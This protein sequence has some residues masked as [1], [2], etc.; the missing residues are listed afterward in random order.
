MVK[1]ATRDE[2][3]ALV[4]IS[5]NIFHRHFKLR[6]KEYKRLERFWAHMRRLSR[7]KDEQ[8]VVETIQAGEGLTYNPVASRKRDRIKVVQRG[9]LLPAMILPVMFQVLSDLVDSDESDEE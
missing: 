1:N 7:A 2:L 9:G 3:L 5:T 6:S 4:E 8:K